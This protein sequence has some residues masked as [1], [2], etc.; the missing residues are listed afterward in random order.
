MTAFI[1]TN[2]LIVE[3]ALAAGCDTLLTEDLQAGQ[4]VDGLTIV[5]PFV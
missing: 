2:A 5:N 1:D 3:S 4:H